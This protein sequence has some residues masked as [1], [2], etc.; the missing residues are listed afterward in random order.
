MNV[1]V[2]TYKDYN[3]EGGE[4]RYLDSVNVFTFHLKYKIIISTTI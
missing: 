1:D 3:I 2:N 4:K